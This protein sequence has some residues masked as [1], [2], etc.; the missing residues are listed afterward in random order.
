MSLLN[1]AADGLIG[2]VI[3]AV[4]AYLLLRH[5]RPNRAQYEAAWKK[6]VDDLKRELAS[7]RA[8]TDRQYEQRIKDLKAE[9]SRLRRDPPPSHGGTTD[10]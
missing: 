5:G 2:A 3:A 7:E 4:P 10:D 8:A 9:N 6:Q 1:N